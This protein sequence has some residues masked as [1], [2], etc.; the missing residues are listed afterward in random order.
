MTAAILGPT[1]EEMLHPVTIEPAIRRRAVAALEESPL[2]PVNL[3]NITWRDPDDRI[4][5]EVLPRALVGVDAPIVV[6]Y[7]RDFPTHA[8]KVG[9]AY[10]VLAEELVYQRVDVNR[11]TVVWPSTGNYGIGGAWV[12]GRV[13]ARSIVVLPEG[14]SRER[15]E[16]IERFG[17]DPLD[18]AMPDQF[19][20]TSM[21]VSPLL[22]GLLGFRPEASRCRIGLAPQLPA[23]WDRLAV[24]RLRTGCGTV[25]V[26]LERGSGRLAIGL[27]RTDPTRPLAVAL[28]PSLPL[29]ATVDGVSVDG[30]SVRFELARTPHDVS[31]RFEV[32]VAQAARVEVRF[33]GGAE[34]VPQQ[35]R[36]HPGDPSRGLRLVDWRLEGGQYVATVE[37]AGDQAFR[38]RSQRP[39]RA[40][41]GGR[42]TGR[43][44]E[45]LT[46]AV[47]L[48]AGRGPLRVILAP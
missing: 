13:G 19:F 21:L 28:E 11:D 12:G 20:S 26:T 36:P 40:I 34:L 8:H 48:G 2:D 45:F 43:E 31:P 27:R 23:D 7:G 16:L 46:V 22:R 38:V 42:L 29:G 3:Y 6:L 14:M 18:T 37:G 33:R 4:K 9:A 39:L 44:R 41:T 15:F 35:T 32:T 24:R 25:D 5:Y 17:Y 1:F 30:R 10:S 47:A